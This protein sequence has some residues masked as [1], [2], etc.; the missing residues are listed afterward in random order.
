M[1]IQNAIK[2]VIK[3]IK[4]EHTYLYL[5]YKTKFVYEKRMAGGELKEPPMKDYCE[6]AVV[7]FNNPKVIEYQIKTLSK[8]FSYP[9]RY[10]VFDNSTDDEKAKII[11]HV[12][13]NHQ[14]GYIR[15]PKQ[16][17]LPKGMGSYSHGMACNYLFNHFF[18]GNN[19]KYFGLLDH[20]IFPVKQFD[21]AYYL[22]KQFFYGIKHGSYIWPGLWFMRMD[23]LNDK[24]ID[25][26]PSIRL[27]GDTGSRNG[28][29]L[30]KNIDF[31]KYIL[32]NTEKRVF[33]GY[34]DLWGGGYEYMSCGWIHCWNA[35]NY[36]NRNTI[37][38]K[39]SKIFTILENYLYNE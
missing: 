4:I 36:M 6:L 28:P 34:N 33:E 22:E 29:I 2:K 12:C 5:A 21:I 35:S 17:F 24:D 31:S 20:D 30:F 11:K 16:E 32:V 38:S 37:D 14:T 10:T 7:A 23:Y 1:K 25:F 9:Y 15:L 13:N 3:R 27:R 8:F 18:R 19:A 26:R 39:M